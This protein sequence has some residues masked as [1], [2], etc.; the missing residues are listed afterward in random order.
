MTSLHL[1]SEDLA[2]G[3]ISIP[4]SPRDDGTVELIVVRPEDD[5]RETPHQVML[6]SARGVEDDHWLKGRYAS[7]P[8]MQLSLINSGV[9][10]LVAG[11][12][13]SRWA[14]AGDNLVVDLDLSQE[15]LPAGTRLEVGSAV[16]AISAKAHRACAKFS[17]RYGT[18]AREFVNLGNGPELRL[19][20]AYA[21]IV[22]D[23]LVTVGDR[24]SKT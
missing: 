2:A 12:D 24:I 20:G 16:I 14:Q 19:R 18:E 3:L 4:K 15:N 13:R 9:L 17:E 7:Q 8:E 11:G 1:S 6:S 5:V 21:T 23:G 22:S 10:D